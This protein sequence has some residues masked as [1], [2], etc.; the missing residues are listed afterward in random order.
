MGNKTKQNRTKWGTFGLVLWPLFLP[1]ALP[2]DDVR[3]F[4][5]ESS[6]NTF[7]R[8]KASVTYGR[9][10]KPSESAS[11]NLLTDTFTVQS[12]PKKVKVLFSKK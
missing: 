5:T 11:D 10:S 6:A 9:I 8:F 4:V 12:L 7:C 3:S 2:T 1:P